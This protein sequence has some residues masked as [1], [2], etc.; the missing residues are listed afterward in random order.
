MKHA[1]ITFGNEESYGL[2]FVGGELLEHGQEIRFF[3]AEESDVADRVAV[4]QPDVACFSP[5]TTFY[6][7]ALAVA[8]D[9]KQKRPSIVTAFGG[10][11]A[12]ACPDIVERQEIDIVVVGPAR[13]AVKRILAGERGLIQSVPTD[14]S[15]LPMPARRAY[16]RDV[17]R[18][19]GR[20]RKVVLSM[21]GCPWNCSYCSSASAHLR[22][23]FGAEAHRRYYLARRP[24]ETVLA[25]VR[26]VVL[27]PTEEIEWVDDDV[28]AGGE[29]GEEWL[30]RFA[31]AWQKE[32][33]LPVYVS[34]TSQ[35]VL[36]ASDRVLDSLRR[37]VNV[38]GMGIQAIRPESLRLFGR[39]WDSEEKM[40]AAYDRLRSFGYA[41][42]L[43]AIVGLPV[44][45]P[46]EDALETV[47]GLQRI[48]TGSVCSIYP[49]M[50]YPGTEM[51][52]Y[53]RGRGMAVNPEC[54][55]DTN[56][57]VPQLL[58]PEK[59]VRRLRNI[60]KLGTLFVK[61]GMDERW[62]RALLDI[63]ID[64]D[65]SRNLSMVRYRE[66]VTDRLGKKGEKIFDEVLATMRLRY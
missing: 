32:V 47:K 1:L 41:V 24:L 15:D 64:E 25:E 66:C 23:V 26:E 45:D 59:T 50:I 51:E 4:W 19:A 39:A 58:F 10:H 18:M 14:P 42:N 11:H 13:G 40:K 37:M 12:M 52:R 22:E 31:D 7:A 57:G 53:C 65:T 43:Q 3:D 36:R 61:V 5:M 6:P 62:M 44:E 38:V 35:L 21:T 56:T 17:P 30:C 48:G 46:V 29:E 16:Y 34:T 33:A 27:Y 54:T 9:L 60:C 28:F 20:Y 2:L 63:D 55:G 8:A 49:L